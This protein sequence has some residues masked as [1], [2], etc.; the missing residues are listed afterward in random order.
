MPET[1]VSFSQLLWGTLVLRPYVFIFLSVYLWLATWHLGIGRT[2]I[3]LLGGYSVA[4]LSEFSSIHTGLPYGLYIYIPATR[5][6]ELWVLGVPFMD[7]LSYV[8][9]SYAS[10]SLAL[11]LLAVRRAAQ[12][13]KPVLKTPEILPRPPSSWLRSSL[14]PWTLSSTPWPCGATAGFWGRFTATPSR[15]SI[16]AFRSAILPVGSWW[17]SS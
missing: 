16:L 13:G 10:Y 11:L 14:S 5:T 15:G 3:Y 6:Q 9:L 4:W 8:F 17:G 12:G 7:S 2:L 1:A